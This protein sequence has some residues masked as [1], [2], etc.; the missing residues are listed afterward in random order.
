MSS[1]RREL[2][3]LRRWPGWALALWR[4]ALLLAIL[5]LWQGGVALGVIDGFFWSSPAKV[6]AS[7]S[8]YL[9]HGDALTDVGYTFRSTLIGF[10]LG[11]SIGSAVGLSFWWSPNYA[12]IAQPYLVAFESMPKLALAPLIVLI[13]GLGITSK[14]AIAVALTVVVS[15]LTTFSGVR[16][17]DQDGERLF[18]SLGATR[19]Q[20]FQKYVIPGVLPWVISI[21][22]VNIGLALTGAVVGEFIA[23]EHGLGRAILYAGETYDVALVWS[24]VMLLSA[25]SFAMYIAVS[26]LERLLVRGV[27]HGAAV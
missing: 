24:G 16:A 1:K 22:R 3:Q 21:L 23:A 25:L 10:V 26:W 17:I 9:T 8:A 5:G 19:W 12:A 14:V 15:C 20:V 4:A 13:F 2:P 18:Y 6:A 27:T 11:T 7:F